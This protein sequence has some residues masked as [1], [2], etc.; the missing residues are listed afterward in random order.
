MSRKRK[1]LEE[2]QSNTKVILL[3]VMYFGQKARVPETL[4]SDDLVKE[5]KV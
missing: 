4:D 2:Q 5:T 3:L 1:L